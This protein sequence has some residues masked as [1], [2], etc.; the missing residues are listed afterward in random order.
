MI[1]KRLMIV[2]SYEE[3]PDLLYIL[4]KF[5]LTK[6]ITV[7]NFGSRD[8]ELHL[9]Y[10]LRLKNIN[11][12]NFYLENK[13]YNNF[14]KKIITYIRTFFF[15]KFQF[16]GKFKEYNKIYFFTPFSVPHIS[17][18]IKYFTK[19]LIYVPSPVLL[20]K[21]FIKSNGRYNLKLKTPSIFEIGYMRYFRHKIF[22]GKYAYFKKL[23]AVIVDAVNEKYLAKII[24]SSHLKKN[25]TIKIL[26]LIGKNYQKYNYIKKKV[27]FKKTTL[28]YFDQHYPQRNLVNNL[29]YLNLI[30][31]LKNLCKKNGINFF[32]KA[33]PG[34]MPCPELSKIKNLKIL[35]SYIPSE[36]LLDKKII[37]A[38]TSSGVLASIFKNMKISLINLI[39]FKDEAFRNKVKKVLKLKIITKIY[40]PSNLDQ[41]KKLIKKNIK[42]RTFIKPS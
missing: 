14:Y 15:Y 29:T 35:D 31:L 40:V 36:F 22:L 20:K 39:P 18:F 42:K 28:I 7:A 13:M 1:M 4:E 16:F 26:S 6:N 5:K 37:I 2:Q 27:K 10:L 38:S 3:I 24:T 23:G 11:V 32:Y 34:K 8:L 25:K 41:L 21:K 17:F 30:S 12:L 33:H 19:N 9:T